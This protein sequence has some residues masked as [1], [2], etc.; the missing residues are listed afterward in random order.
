MAAEH[1]DPKDQG[2]TRARVLDVAERLFAERGFDAVSL[3]HITAEAGVNVAAVNYHFGSK[4]KLIFE[5]MARRIEPVNARRLAMLD[6]AEAAAG[7]GIL[8]VETIL[9]ALYWPLASELSEGSS[10]R[11]I[12]LMLMGRCMG[13]ANPHVSTMI[14]EEFREVRERFMAALGRSFPGR[15]SPELELKFFFSVGVLIHTLRQADRLPAFL[16]TRERDMPDLESLMRAII[17]YAAAGFR[18]DFKLGLSK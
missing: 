9:E 10:R 5:V 12:S 14:V 4:D 8:E 1:G 11:E 16:G 7:D 18:A 2:E 3:R 15:V 13:E 6:E 17:A